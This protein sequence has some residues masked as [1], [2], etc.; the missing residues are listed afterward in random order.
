[1]LQCPH[2][3]TPCLV[4]EQIQEQFE[5]RTQ[6]VAERR[7][8]ADVFYPFGQ[9]QPLRDDSGKLVRRKATLRK[10]MASDIVADGVEQSGLAFQLG[11]HGGGG[12][13]PHRDKHGKVVA[14]RRCPQQQQDPSP[15]EGEGYNPWG[16]P[17]CGAPKRSKYG[18]IEAARTAALSREVNQRMYYK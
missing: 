5:R 9:G 8:P 7:G 6:E 17:G 2:S 3:P 15:S 16:R 1:M 11:C 12:G 10:D 18:Q 4:E 13:A 14:V